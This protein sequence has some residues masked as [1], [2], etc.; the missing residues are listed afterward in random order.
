MEIVTLK[1]MAEVCVRAERTEAISSSRVRDAA[2]FFEQ[3][4]PRPAAPAAVTSPG[5]RSRKLSQPNSNAPETVGRTVGETIEVP[6]RVT[7]WIF[8]TRPAVESRTVAKEITETA[9][10]SGTHT[11]F[12]AWLLVP[13][14]VAGFACLYAEKR[15]VQVCR[16]WCG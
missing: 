8:F 15:I 12:H 7:R 13:M 9:Y 11:A 16:R 4:R 10:S 3:L 6:V 5:A 1:A 2:A 14:F